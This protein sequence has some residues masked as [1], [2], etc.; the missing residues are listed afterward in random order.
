MFIVMTVVLFVGLGSVWADVK[1]PAIFSDHM[2][3]QRNEAIRVWGW[4]DAGETVSVTLGEDT[5]TTTA[6]SVGKWQVTLGARSAGDPTALT[7]KGNNTVTLTDVVMGEVWICSG[8]SNMQWSF[9][10][11]VDNG[12]EEVAAA[13]YPGI[14]LITVPRITANTPQEDFEGQWVP[15]TPESVKP[16]SA[17]GYFFGRILHRELNVPVGLISTNWG[18][19]RVEAWTSTGD[20][21]QTPAAGPVLEAWQETCAA[22]DPVKAQTQYDDAIKKWEQDAAQAKADNKPAPRRPGKQ[23]DPRVSPHHPANLYNSMI[24][25]LVP[26]SV[27]G[28]IWYQGESNVARAYQYREL[29]PLMIR[30]WRRDFLNPDM[31]FGFVQLA[32]YNYGGD[33]GDALPELWEAQVMTLKHLKNIGMAVTTDIATT[34]NI[35]PPNKQDVGKR[36]GLWALATIYGERVVYSGPIYQGCEV[37][38]DAVS[39]SFS[40]VGSGLTTSDGEM[41]SHFTVAGADRVFHPAAAQIVGSRVIVSSDEVKH[42]VAVRFAWS[43]TAEPNLKNR[44]G[45]PASPFRTDDWPG[46]TIDTVRP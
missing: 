29:F 27:R 28:A 46:I 37:H 26:L 25:P 43:N 32:P 15:C 16:F 19:T 3:L 21:K 23:A 22:Y 13:E 14:R 9:N 10:N 5:A 31:P 24:A 17:V 40:H 41:P 30:N 45:L 20:L 35:H 44:E 18:G 6:N 4:A 8:Q 1:L 12:A 33:R 11:N 7:V 34:S 42:P 2:V 36:L 38:A 39:I